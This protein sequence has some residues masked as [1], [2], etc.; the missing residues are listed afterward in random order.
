MTGSGGPGVTVTI[1]MCAFVFHYKSV[2]IKMASSISS[3]ASLQYVSRK[4]SGVSLD[5]RNDIS[6]FHPELSGPE[7]HQPDA[8]P[9]SAYANFSPDTAADRVYTSASQSAD[10][11]RSFKVGFVTSN[12]HTNPSAGDV[13]TAFE[14]AQALQSAYRNV[15]VG[16]LRR[17]K[18]WYDEKMLGDIDIIV[19]LLDAYDLARALSTKRSAGG[20]RY[21]PR[22][23]KSSLIAIAWIRNWHH[24][25]LARP[26]IGNYDMLLTSSE[27]ARDSLVG[28]A[29]NI[30]LQTVCVANCPCGMS[31]GRVPAPVEILRLATNPARFNQHKK[32]LSRFVAD[33][34]FTGSYYNVSRDIMQL[35]PSSLP[36]K[37][38]IVGSGWDAAPNVSAEFL[39]MLRGSVPYSIVPSVYTSVKVG[40]ATF[41]YWAKLPN[42]PP[43]SLTHPGRGG[44]REPRHRPMGIPQQPRVR[45]SGQRC[46]RHHQLQGWRSRNIRGTP[47][48]ICDVGGTCIATQPKLEWRRG[49]NS[50]DKASSTGG[51]CESHVRHSSGGVLP[52]H[53]E[54]IQRNFPQEKGRSRSS[55]SRS[56]AARGGVNLRGHTN[57]ARPRKPARCATP[58][59]RRT[60]AT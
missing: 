45:C 37:G 47:A 41:S 30:G 17:G 4:S 57:N 51:S 18:D 29:I 59:F 52:D 44:R 22:G 50:L 7:L 14:L 21:S 43:F 24:R 55:S 49:H 20:N 19:V 8:I 42:P 28:F 9:Y 16:Y 56:S 13:F 15:E 60:R 33:Y 58:L 48:H 34:A 53:A 6:Y 12:P 3:S 25:W 35:R 39:E 54:E 11:V 46:T 31:L 38:V 40:V 27:A 36:F 2:T 32:P 10:K 5:R 1:A 23:A 26:W